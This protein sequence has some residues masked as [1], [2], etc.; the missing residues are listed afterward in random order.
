MKLPILTEN[1]TSFITSTFSNFLF[2][3]LTSKTPIFSPLFFSYNTL[4]SF[5]IY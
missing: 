5:L 3:L 2:K 4:I 1:D